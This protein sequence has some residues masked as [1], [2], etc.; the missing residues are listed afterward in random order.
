MGA[1]AVGVG[2]GKRARHQGFDAVQNFHS[3]TGVDDAVVAVPLV[4]EDGIVRGLNL[5]DR[6]VGPFEFGSVN[7]ESAIDSQPPE[8]GLVLKP[9]GLDELIDELVRVLEVCDGG[10]RFICAVL[11]NRNQFLFRE[12][13]AEEDLDENRFSYLLT[14][15]RFG[16]PLSSSRRPFSVIE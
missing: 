9:E 1:V 14:V 13:G 11:D 2:S 5:T 6:L 3:H 10:A 7:L 8:E 16:E 4:L 12:R 15:G